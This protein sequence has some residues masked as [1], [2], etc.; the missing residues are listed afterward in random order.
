M[1]TVNFPHYFLSVNVIAGIFSFACQYFK[2]RSL[3]SGPW[4]EIQLSQETNYP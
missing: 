4:W 3:G 2:I 1:C